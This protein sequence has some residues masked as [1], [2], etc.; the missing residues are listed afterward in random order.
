MTTTITTT[1]SNTSGRNKSS[2]YVATTRCKAF[3]SMPTDSNSQRAGCTIS[4]FLNH[5][6]N[7]LI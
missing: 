6:A 4:T 2:S 5:A 3:D 7:W 1:N